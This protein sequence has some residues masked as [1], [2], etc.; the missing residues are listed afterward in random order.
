MEIRTITQGEILIVQ[1]RGPMQLGDL[2][3][4]VRHADERG[5]HSYS[6]GRLYDIRHIQNHVSSVSEHIDAVEDW[7]QRAPAPEQPVVFVS[8]RGWAIAANR[9]VQKLLQLDNW[10][11]TEDLESAFQ[12][13]GIEAAPAALIARLENQPAMRL[14]SES[15][16]H[17]SDCARID[18]S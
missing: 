3:E 8:N 18:N 6:G 7:L 12:I 14:G 2:Y 16:T 10:H 13:L 9:L 4:L 11:V 5:F 17:E 1:L 15:E